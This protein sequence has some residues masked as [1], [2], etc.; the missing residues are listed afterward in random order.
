MTPLA[1]E[2]VGPLNVCSTSV[3][4]RGNIAGATIEIVVAGNVVSSHMSTTPDHVYPIGATLLENQQVTARQKIATG[5]TSGDSLPVTVQ[6][7]PTQLSSLTVRT[8]LHTC[9]RAVRVTGA[10]PGAKIDVMIGGQQVGA[11]VAAKGWAGVVYD[12]GAGASGPLTLQQI[13]CNNLTATQATAAPV[14]FTPPLS[15]PVIETPLFECQSRITI[16]GVA[17][18]AYVELYRNNSTNPEE[19]F[20][21]S[22]PKEF[23]WIKPLVKNDVIRVRQGYSCKQPAPPLEMISSFATATVQPVTA[24][25]APKFIGVPCPGSTFVTLTHLVPGARVIISQN[26]GELGE[27]DAPDVTYTFPVPALKAGATVTA[28]MEMCNG[29]GPTGTVQVGT[30]SVTPGIAVSPPYACASFVGLGLNGTEGNYLVYITNKNGQQISPYHNLI[31]DSTLVPVFPSLVAGDQITVHVQACGGAWKTYGPTTVLSGPPQPVIQQPVW[32][33]YN[34]VKVAAVAGFVLD[35]YVNNDWRESEISVGVDSRNTFTLP[36]AFHAGDQISCVMTVCGVVGKPTPPVTVA[37]EPPQ[38]PILMEPPTGADDV[39]LQ[40]ALIWKDPGAGT[41]GAATSFHVVVT[42]GGNTVIDT[43]ATSTSY[44]PSAPLANDTHYQW[45]VTSI[46]AGGQQSAASPFLFSTEPPPAGSL[47]FQP[48]MTTDVPG[49]EFVRDKTFNVFINVVNQGNAESAAY[50]VR[51][52]ATAAEIG[53][54]ADTGALPM[55][56]LAPGATATAKT[57]MYIDS[58]TTHGNTVEID[59]FLLVNN[60]QVDHAFL[61]G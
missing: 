41:P 29:K 60:Q 31:G 3:E 52:T 47:K 36:A 55:A 39:F 53:Q 1:P 8:H 2:V 42:T 32:A 58:T 18:G 17:D 38:Q 61:D 13:T 54:F 11:E 14:A 37:L 40:P 44:T 12:P 15:T 23:R 4:V 16:G 19:R 28:H 27:T 26:G 30:A 56:A 7:A 50:A 43:T 59:A 5:P 10:V 35:L 57:Q 24:L 45:T 25:H 46:N 9:G 48:P 21:F 51:F 49:S 22:V 33:G 20:V 6:A 34:S